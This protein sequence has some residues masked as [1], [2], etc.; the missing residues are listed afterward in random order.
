M[1][2]FKRFEQFLFLGLGLRYTVKDIDLLAAEAAV[3]ASTAADTAVSEITAKATSAVGD[4]G[5]E[6]VD[7]AYSAAQIGC[8]AAAASART[9]AN[10]NEAIFSAAFAISRAAA[11]KGDDGEF[12]RSV[13][14]G[15]E[16]SCRWLLANGKDQRLIDQ[17]LWLTGP[18]KFP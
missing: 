10:A 14:S 16:V 18:S 8:V 15:M 12:V 6:V 2:F 1:Q 3:I 17:P 13:W 11:T 5:I 4:L 9:L 7:G